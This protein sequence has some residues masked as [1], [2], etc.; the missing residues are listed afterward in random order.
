MSDDILVDFSSNETPEPNENLCIECN[1]YYSCKD[2]KCSK[3]Y[4]GEYLCVKCKEY[5]CSE[6]NGM[7]SYCK[8]YDHYNPA[9]LSLNEIKKLPDSIFKGDAMGMHLVELYDEY[10][11][12]KNLRH[13]ILADNNE[14]KILRIICK[15]QSS[16]EIHAILR[17]Y[18]DFPAVILPAKYASELLEVVTQNIPNNERWRCEHAISPFVLDIWNMPCGQIINCYYKHGGQLLHCPR[19]L[20]ELYWLWNRQYRFDLGFNSGSITKAHLTTCLST[21]APIS[22]HDEY[23]VCKHCYNICNITGKYPYNMLILSKCPYCSY[24]FDELGKD[25]I[26]NH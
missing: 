19:S 21:N 2:N 26:V 9:T 20:Q 23:C 25:F 11:S 7:C 14:F 12:E 4:N 10:K 5:F 24:D 18:R 13:K 15:D 3:C 8:L 16:G 6:K 1:T 17:G 22:T